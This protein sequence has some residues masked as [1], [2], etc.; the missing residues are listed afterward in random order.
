M[1]AIQQIG[2]LADVGARGGGDDILRHQITS[3]PTV[4]SHIIEETR[5]EF[6]AIREQFRPPVAM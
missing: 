5:R 4:N 2:D 3:T 1:A 6:F